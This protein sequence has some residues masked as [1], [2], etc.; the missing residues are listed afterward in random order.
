[1]STAIALVLTQEEAGAILEIID[2]LSGGSPE[3]VFAW[4]GS[5]SLSDPTTRAAAKLFVAVGQDVPAECRAIDP[6]ALE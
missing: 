3:N 5:D 2:Q 6:T 1:M 4:D